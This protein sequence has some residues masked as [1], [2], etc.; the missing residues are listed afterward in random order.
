MRQTIQFLSANYIFV[1]V[2]KET[3]KIVDNSEDLPGVA[4]YDPN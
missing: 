1:G 3:G 4:D 2:L